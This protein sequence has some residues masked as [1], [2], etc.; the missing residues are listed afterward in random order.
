MEMNRRGFAQRMFGGLL[1]SFIAVSLGGCSFESVVTQL[2]NWVPVALSALNGILKIL[3]AVVPP[4]V[5]AIITLIQAGFAALLAAIQNYQSGKGVLADIV[6]A[7]SAIEANFQQFFASLNVP[8]GLLAT[9]EGLATILLSTISAFAAELSPAP[10]PASVQVG[11]NRVSYGPVK[12]S[13]KTFR[14][15][16]NRSCTQSGHPEAEI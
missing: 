8:S 7:I 13:V 4:Q 2:K 11:G 6:S 1:A 12:R 15:D 3:G 14:S 16:W 10:T 9:I 5:T